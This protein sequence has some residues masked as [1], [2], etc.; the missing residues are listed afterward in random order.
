MNI[1]KYDNFLYKTFT[2]CVYLIITRPPNGP[3]LFRLAVI[4]C[5]TAGGRQ[6]LH[7][8]PVVLHPV[9][10]TPCLNNRNANPSLHKDVETTTNQYFSDF[11]KLF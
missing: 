7:G 4:V 6:T 2:S 1:Y 5:N 9:R 10:A 3:V 8:G 11:V